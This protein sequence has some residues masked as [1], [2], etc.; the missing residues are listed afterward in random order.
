VA[1]VAS[2]ALGKYERLSQERHERDLELAQQPSG[3]PRKLWFDAAA[4]DRAVQFVEG[5]CQHHKGEWAGKPL[6]L[7]D[8]Q[9]SIVRQIFGW[10]RADGTRRYRIAYVEVP[11]KNGKSTLAA[12]LGLYLLVGDQEPGAEVYSSATKREQAKIVWDEAF[13]TVKK[14]PKLQRFVRAFRN[15]LHCE[16]L[17]SKFEPLSADAGTLDGLNPHGNIIDELHAHKDRGVWDV[18]DTAMG[19]RRQPLTLAITTAGTYDPESIGWQQHDYACKV[20]EGVV[21]DDA[22]YAFIAAADEGDDFFTDAAQQKANPGYGISVK[23]SYLQ[24][25]AVKARAQPSFTNEYFRLHLN[26]WPQQV[27]RWL[28]LEQWGA[29]DPIPDGLDPWAHARAREAQLAGRVCFGGL[30]LSSKLDLTALVLAFPAEDSDVVDLLC[31]F[32]LPEATI[33]RYSRK[34]QRQYE[35][36]AREG[37]LS[38]TPGNVIDYEFIRAEVN[39]LATKYAVKEIAFDPWGST[40]LATQLMGDG[41]VMVET[42][43]GYKTL[44]EPAKDLEARIVDGNVR[45][46]GNPVLRFCV[47]NA[48]ITKDSAGNIKP[49]KEKASARIDG[50][51]AAVMAL[52]RVICAKNEPGSYLDSGEVVVLG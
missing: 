26:V 49:D 48:V 17:G 45:H 12:A 14:S 28:S 25:Q 51:V 19:A 16:R 24:E 29:S 39:A 35:A 6:L 8:W 7:S 50:V 23:P 52:S 41:H 10:K 15:N 9:R 11:R 44:S 20:L 37:W 13:K 30:D 32:W 33:E 42:R 21:Q 27:T 31:R 36:W 22:F 1:Q 34:G 3:H 18:L 5:Y 2:R 47:A 43:Q 4:G 38:K 46:A 40:Q